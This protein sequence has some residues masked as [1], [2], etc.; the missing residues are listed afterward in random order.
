LKKN[1]KEV[2][3]MDYNWLLATI[4]QSSAALVGIS[5]GFLVLRINMFI[6]ERRY[7]MQEI[8]DRKDEIEK[9]VDKIIDNR[10]IAGGDNR[11]LE[12]KILYD[13][14]LT[15]LDEKNFLKV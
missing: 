12:Q 11:I 9:D 8:K 5:S 4:A 10:Q 6:N 7:I 13:K 14:K 2:T 1:R 15:E 3:I